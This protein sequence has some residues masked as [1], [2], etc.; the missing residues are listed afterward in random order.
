MIERI[1][2][3]AALRLYLYQFRTG[4]DCFLAIL[5]LMGWSSRELAEHPFGVG[6]SA[7]DMR[8]LN[9]KRRFIVAAQDL[10]ND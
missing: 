4:A 8:L 9:G 1:T 7:I 2:R 5:N 3:Q 10:F 6:R